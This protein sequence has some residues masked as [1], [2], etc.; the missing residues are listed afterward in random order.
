VGHHTMDYRRYMQQYNAWPAC[1][2]WRTLS[3]PPPHQYFPALLPLLQPEADT[4]AAALLAKTGT[5]VAG[6]FKR[7]WD[8]GEDARLATSADPLRHVRLPFWLIMA[9]A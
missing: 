7:A 1:A 2:D 8:L 3:M 9:C 4:A 5:A 6:D